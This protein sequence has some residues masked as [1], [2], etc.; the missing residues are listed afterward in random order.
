[1]NAAENIYAYLFL[2]SVESLTLLT[3]C[4]VIP[5]CHYFVHAF[6]KFIIKHFYSDTYSLKANF[7]FLFTLL[8]AFYF[9]CAQ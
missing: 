9:F 7:L 6:C 5:V 8:L 4:A 3:H 1:M 2:L